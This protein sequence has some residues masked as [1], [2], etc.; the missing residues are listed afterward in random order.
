MINSLSRKVKKLLLAVPIA[1]LLC[2]GLSPLI[3]N[4]LAATQS[5][6]TDNTPAGLSDCVKHNKIITDLNTVVNFLGAAVGVIVIGTIIV[7]GIQYSLAGDSP[8]ALGK[9]KKRIL[10][11]LVALAA[12]IFVYSFLQWIIPGGIFNP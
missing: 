12:F 7:G 3:G 5:S 8:D 1:V 6:C 10:N 2:L 4:G 11:G 9:A